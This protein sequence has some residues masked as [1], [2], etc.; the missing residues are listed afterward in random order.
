MFAVHSRYKREAYNGSPFAS[1]ILHQNGVKVVLKSTLFTLRIL[2]VTQSLVTGDHPV[3]DSRG[4]IYEAAM[5]HHF[6]LPADKALAAVTS[7]SAEV[8]GLGHRLGKIKPGYDAGK[9]FSLRTEG[10]I[11]SSG[12]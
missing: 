9:D 1:K 3:I 11:S 12:L 4:L 6:G 5:A 7:I 8:A 2:Q 10:S